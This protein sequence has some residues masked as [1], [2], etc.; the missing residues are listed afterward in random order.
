MKQLL[1]IAMIVCIGAITSSANTY[2]SGPVT[3][4]VTW[5]AA[6]SP[7]VVVGNLTVTAEAN[8]TIQ[9]GAEIQFSSN[10]LFM[11]RG[12]VDAQ[13]TELSPVIFTKAPSAI[14]AGSIQ[15][16][17]T[18]YSSLL[19]ASFSHC[20]F[21]HLSGSNAVSFAYANIRVTDCTLANLP[22]NAFVA[23]YSDVYFAANTIRDVNEGIN[24][25]Y[26][27][28]TISSNHIVGIHGH[29][30]GI[31][32]DFEWGGTGDK[33]VR[34]EWNIV[35]DGQDFGA[36][37]DGIDVGSTSTNVVIRYNIVHGFPDKGI[38]VGEG[39]S[40]NLY[41][42][43]VYD[44]AMG[45]GIKDGSNPEIVNCTV[46]ECA[47]G[48]VA[49][50]ELTGPA[51]PSMYNTIV[52]NCGNGFVEL[53]GSLINV[54]NSV[55]D[56][57]SRWAGTGGNISTDPLFVDG[58]NRNYRLTFP[59]PCNDAGLDIP[60]T[61]GTVD[62]DGKP[63]YHATT[64]DMGVYESPYLRARISQSEDDASQWGVRGAVNV[65]ATEFPMPTAI[66][67]W[68]G[69]RFAITSVPPDAV[70]QEA[71]I[72]FTSDWASP[73]AVSVTIYGEAHDNAPTFE[74]TKFS[75]S[76]RTTTISSVSWDIAEWNAADECG[77][78]QRTPN[79][80]NIIGEIVSRPGWDPTNAIVFIFPNAG[81][82]TPYRVAHAYDGDPSKAPSLFIRY[83]VSPGCWLGVSSGGNGHV[84]GGNERVPEGSNAVIE[85]IADAFYHFMEWSGDIEP[86]D[87]TNNPLNVLMETDRT[88]VALFGENM[89]TNSTPEWW[90]AQYGLGT[91]D[92]D[93]LEHGDADGM[94]NWE[95]Y[96]AGT[97]PTNSDSALRILDIVPDSGGI[98]INWQGGTS[99]WQYIQRKQDLLSTGE[100]WQAIFT[101][102]PPTSV[103]TNLIDMGATNPVLFYRIKVERP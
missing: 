86:S 70:I 27:R 39:S 53:D 81:S 41:N 89:V 82:L 9:A 49:F 48:I 57:G 26:S 47:Q 94:E 78:N 7:Y 98:R 50:R 14:T 28:G 36:S 19:N 62:L 32:I 60:W 64:I 87:M 54:T 77:A 91:N 22:A 99:V 3:G 30:D 80:A 88:I 10:H 11:V 93:A 66:T 61:Q 67:S 76:S 73:G 96:V 97:D 72:Q 2:V 35:E 103:S 58:S 51:Y 42:N 4:N 71:I 18:N 56:M 37:A 95:E 59:S 102:I 34:I 17:G 85:A 21:E 75:I 46:V 100:L 44:C 8:L 31:D 6:D 74:A 5:T 25:R 38:S 69:L 90:L 33:N 63:R 16:E 83:E 12:S 101:N 68:G 40:P 20:I 52:W 65:V 15:V 29:N 55:V 45:I 92:A 79:L 43:L 84:S 1:Y 23:F 24:I 13:G